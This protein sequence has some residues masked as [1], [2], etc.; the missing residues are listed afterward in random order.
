MTLNRLNRTKPSRVHC[1][2]GA[3]YPSARRLLLALRTCSRLPAGNSRT[4]LVVGGLRRARPYRPTLGLIVF[5]PRVRLSRVPLRRSSW[6]VQQRL[7]P[8]NNFLRVQA[9]LRRHPSPV[10]STT[11][12]GP[13]GQVQQSPLHLRLSPNLHA[14]LPLPQRRP[15]RQ[16]RSL[17]LLRPHPLRPASLNVRSAPLLRSSR[18]ASLRPRKTTSSI[19][20]RV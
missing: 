13:T 3:R 4:T 15:H 18:R 20:W 10:G 6:G 14:R 7:A 17:R 12:P 5:P 19:S 1:K 11:M 2:R 8:Y 9:L 16:R